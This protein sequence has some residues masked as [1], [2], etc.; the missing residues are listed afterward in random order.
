MNNNNPSDNV[1]TDIW[2]RKIETPVSKEEEKK[3]EPKKVEELNTPKILG[4]LG[5][6]K[7]T[8]PVEAKPDIPALKN[9]SPQPNHNTFFNQ[10]DLSNQLNENNTLN[11]GMAAPK[12][13]VPSQVQTP[14]PNVNVQANPNVSPATP[15]GTIPEEPALASKSIGK[16]KK[17]KQKSPLA[18]VILFTVL[19][20]TIFFI[21]EITPYFSDLLDKLNISD[22]SDVLDEVPTP[23]LPDDDEEEEPL[24]EEPV[25]ETYLIDP[26][27]IAKYENIEISNVS[28]TMANNTYYFNYTLKNIDTQNGFDFATNRV[29]IDFYQDNTYLG[30]ALI[31]IDNLGAGGTT[32]MQSPIDESIYTNANSFQVVNRNVSDYPISELGT[33]I[34]CEAPNRTLT[35]TF[36]DNKLVSIRDN[37]NYI[38]VD[39]NSYTVNF[40]NYQAKALRVEESGIATANALAIDTGFTYTATINYTTDVDLTGE[41]IYYYKK[42]TSKDVLNYEIESLGFTCH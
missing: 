26:T 38:K 2:G 22:N 39:D 7:T 8:P 36:Q 40:L 4:N 33:V 1:N 34:T 14:Q 37:Y 41:D 35:Y 5:E 29:Y 24:P 18:M 28:K 21:P 11:N 3:E 6:D 10:A 20:A 42:D 12:Q 15:T 23:S 13:P 27:V 31:N 19:I 9:S 17:D 30:R 25:I 16:I 32:T